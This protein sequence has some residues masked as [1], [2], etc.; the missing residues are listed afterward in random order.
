[1]NPLGVGLVFAPA[2]LPL[3]RDGNEAVSVLE[4][5]PQTLWQLLRTEGRDTYLP[6][7]ERAAELAALPQR[8]LLHSIGLPV[9]SSRPLEDEQLDLLR[10]M[11]A[12]LE[13]AWV[14]EHL[15]FNAFPDHGGWSNAGFLLPPLQ[16]PETVAV[17]ATK[18]RA[19][20]KALQRPVAFE[21]GVN[22]LAPRDGELTDGEFFAAVAESADSGIL[23]DLHN[24]WTNERNGR[25]PAA[26]VLARLPLERVWEIHLAGGAELDGYWLDAHA[27]AVP[28][29]VLDLAAEWIPRM[30]NLG[31]LVFEILDEHI[32]GLGLDGVARQLEQMRGLWALRPSVREICVRAPGRPETQADSFQ[33][34]VVRRW[35]NVL[36]SLVLGRDPGG[37]LASRLRP[38]PGLRVLRELVSDARASFISDGLHYTV[39]LLL[40]SLGAAGARELLS[41][42][43]RSRPPELFA[44]AESDA[45]AVFLMQKDLSIPYLDEV[46]QFEHAL[47]RAALYQEG[48]TVLFAHEPSRLFECLEQGQ[49]PRGLPHQ[50]TSLFVR[51][52]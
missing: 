21:T 32:E 52:G 41:E 20:A 23:L 25:T 15:S 8:K 17:A 2:L 3:L 48:S 7:G 36:G 35:E 30:P 46:L 14:S 27:G 51:A 42:F 19:F 39:S 44:S 6:N 37:S 34:A 1:M 45:F 43:M 9:G 5:E 16:C 4:I 10:A 26:D 12:S 11:V 29:Q 49:A 47:I 18:L 50:E 24:L 40:C 38:D 31:A 13:P 33:M 28:P 22:Y